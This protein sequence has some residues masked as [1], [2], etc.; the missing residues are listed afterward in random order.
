MAHEIPFAL[1]QLVLLL[2]CANRS[3][4]STGL[5]AHYASL[6]HRRLRPAWDEGR[7]VG[8]PT[9]TVRAILATNR[10]ERI[11]VRAPASLDVRRLEL[12]M[13]GCDGVATTSQPRLTYVD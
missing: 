9:N 4:V 10:I 12:T 11:T 13:L 5:C 8:T 6:H 2:E 1:I 7:N 3:L